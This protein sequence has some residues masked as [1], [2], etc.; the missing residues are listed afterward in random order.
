MT[1]VNS[2]NETTLKLRRTFAAPREKVFKAWTDPSMLKEWFHSSD[3]WVTPINEIDLRVGGRYRLGMQSPD[4]D[5][6]YVVQGTYREIEPPQKLVFTWSWEGKDENAMLVTILFRE[7]GDE[8]EIELIH[9]QFSDSDIRDKHEHG[10]Q[11]CFTQLSKLLNNP[12]N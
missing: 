8:T 9:E 3:G 7:I 6:P 5:A 4:A 10:W 12:S 2:N 1:D 11:G